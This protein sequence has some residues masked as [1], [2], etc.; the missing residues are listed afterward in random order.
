MAFQISTLKYDIP[1]ETITEQ[2]STEVSEN[3][4]SIYNDFMEFIH[5]MQFQGWSKRTI[6]TYGN[7]IQ[8][9]VDFLIKEKTI[10]ISEEIN[11]TFLFKYQHHIHSRRSSSGKPITS[12]SIY[13]KLVSMR[14]YLHFL[15]I[16]GRINFR[17]ELII[18]L[19]AKRQPLPKNILNEGQIERLL[20]KPDVLKLLGLRNKAI[21]EL[22]YASGIRNMELRKFI[23]Q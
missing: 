10:Q 11:P 18:K 6:E 8:Q 7:N 14:S 23:I 16:N 15:Y 12:S 5:W 3:T 17:P 13:T 4:K 19:P 21:I 9:F 20:T 2:Y 22:L 1:S